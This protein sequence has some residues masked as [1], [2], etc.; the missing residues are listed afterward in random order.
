[1]PHMQQTQI[2]FVSILVFI[3]ITLTGSYWT[4]VSHD[5]LDKEQD[6]LLNQIATTQASAIERRLTLSLAA[7]H[8]LAQELIR[9]K[10]TFENF[11][12]YAKN[13]IESIGGVANLQLA[14]NGIISQIYPLSG[15][16]KA[17]GLN[18]LEHPIYREA[19]QDSIREQKLMVAGPF[20]LV[21]G[22]VAL[23][24]RKP[25]FIKNKANEEVFWGFV[26]AMIYLDNL[27]DTTELQ[28]L[29]GKGYL[30]Q[31][32]RTLNESGETIV[33]VKP[34]R[35]FSAQTVTVNVVIPNGNWQLILG[36]TQTMKSFTLVDG[37]LISLVLG[38]FIAFATYAVLLQP[39]RLRVIVQQKTA[40]LHKLAYTDPLTALSNRRLFTSQM[41]T[42]IASAQ[43][44]PKI[45]AFAYFDIDNFKQ[46]NDS[47]GHDVGDQVLY[48]AAQRLQESL[49]PGDSAARLGGDEFGV[50]L[51]DISD[52]ASIENWCYKVIKAMKPAFIIADQEYFISM[53]FGIVLI[54]QDGDNLVSLMQHADMAMYHAKHLGKRQFCFY[55]PSM[56]ENT[57]QRIHWQ[58]DLR[59]AILKDQFDLFYQPQINTQT[60]TIVGAEAL[61]RWHHPTRGL[62]F[63]D[64]FIGLAEE[65]GQIIEI[66]YWVIQQ[67]CGY[68][69]RRQQQDLPPLTI[70][71]NLSPLQLG[72]PKLRLFIRDTLAQ[73]HIN[74]IYLGIEVTEST[75]LN[76]LELASSMLMEFKN[77]GIN[78]ALD[79][80]GTG[81]SSLKLLKDLPFDN[82]KIDRSF[83]MD[84]D[85][86][87]EDRQIIAAIIAM[88]HTLNLKVT[89][90]G[91]E[92]ATQL[93]RLNQLACN[94]GQG[95]LISRPITEHEFEAFVLL[96]TDLASESR[97]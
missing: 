31:L 89:A 59:Q 58:E 97:R 44:S 18:I 3:V 12:T 34:A 91:I 5:L 42:L 43:D 70:Y 16:E 65:T 22:G 33:F 40:E 64:E 49:Q 15:N 78:I 96:N 54:P 82:L 14:P 74:P 88:C 73:T 61:I 55:H 71:I 72:D 80:F 50:I 1:M 23:L 36:R 57:L 69:Q 87:A 93:D 20:S 63:P 84:S 39:S 68:I 62:V 32:S 29:G 30:F 76:D 52:P 94:F 11:D 90:E 7:T 67:V 95:Y 19:T 53:S 86:N 56:K 41:E 85:D 17:I 6:I 4:Q 45:T 10:G 77:M 92:T 60:N 27:L 13:T 9:G 79:D 47:I 37:Y 25:V 75:L 24:G 51:R 83:V 46:I 8:V 2:V 28:Q 48:I 66:G 21:Q 81:Y 26:S 38:I 35:P